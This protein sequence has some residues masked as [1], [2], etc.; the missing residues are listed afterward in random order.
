MSK[1]THDRQDELRQLN[2]D[3]PFNSCAHIGDVLRLRRQ[4][5]RE[6]AVA[7]RPDYGRNSIAA[8]CDRYQAGK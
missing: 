3:Q 2:S 1:N 8:Y 4:L 7:G 5:L 6:W